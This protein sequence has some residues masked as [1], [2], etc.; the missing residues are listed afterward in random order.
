[1]PLEQTPAAALA[2][3]TAAQVRSERRKSLEPRLKCVLCCLRCLLWLTSDRT[4]VTV[5]APTSIA[6]ATT[7]VESRIAVS[8]MR[9]S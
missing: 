4:G 7:S 2:G 8:L 6:V 1:M 5:A 9:S 3:L